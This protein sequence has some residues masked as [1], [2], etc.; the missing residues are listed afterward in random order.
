MYNSSEYVCVCMRVL[1]VCVCMRVFRV[2]VHACVVARK[3][4]IRIARHTE[5]A[6]AVGASC[7]R[8]CVV[9]VSC[10]C[11]DSYAHNNKK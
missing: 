3:V 2:C 8:V 4:K 5:V 9:C 1:R 10:V 11:V 6:T 7:V